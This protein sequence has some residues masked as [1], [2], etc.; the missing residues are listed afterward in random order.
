MF[1]KDG[2]KQIGYDEFQKLHVFVQGMTTGFKK[3]DVSGDGKLDGREVRSALRDSGYE[4]EEGCFQELMRKFDE[5]RVG[6]LTFED[7]IDMS[8]FVGNVRR[9]FAFYDRQQT[10]QVTFNFNNFMTAAVTLK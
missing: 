6:A 3:R 5:K 9:T 8:I 1:D 10:G 2:S 7:Y 4:L